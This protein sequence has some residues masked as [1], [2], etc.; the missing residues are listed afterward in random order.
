MNTFRRLKSEHSL[1]C[2][3]FSTNLLSRKRQQEEGVYSVHDWAELKHLCEREGLSK[4]AAA[5]KLGMSR[6][7][8]HRLLLLPEPPVYE[9]E[10]RSS[11]LDPYREA[12]L[13]ML[14]EDPTVRATVIRERL[15]ASGYG[16]GITIL[17][18]FVVDARPQ[19][20]AAR[21]Y[22]RTSYLPGEIG[23]VD[24][25][26]LPVRLPLRE[27]AESK[28]YALVGTLP[29]SAAHAAFFTHRKTL[30]DFLPALLDCLSR[31]GGVPSRLVLDNDTSMV[32]RVPGHRSRLHPEA[33][34]LFGALRTKPV[35]LA[36]R[37]PTS[38]GQVERTV[39]YLE[40]SFLP[41]RTFTSIEDLQAQHDT[42]T[43]EIAYRRSPRR[44]GARV[45][46]AYL[47]EKGYLSPLPDPLP[48]TDQQ[49]ETRISKDAFVRMAGADY[50]VP[51]GL[52]G[53]R[54]QIRL[55]LSSVLVYL[56][57]RE[58]ARH[59]RSYVPADVVIDPDH[60]RALLESREASK[61]LRGGDVAVEIP[62]LARYDALLGV[63]L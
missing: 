29:H 40:T 14:R 6:T 61:R 41:L 36:P 25:W 12:I 48:Q 9:R 19:F 31:L 35:I 63:T 23:Q 30:H 52:V 24:W 56:E 33:A 11:L 38:K 46:D 1:R 47:V 8:V 53:R 34:A 57:G 7:T 37:R 21:A 18:D 4:K 3:R 2:A 54:V 60:A 16:G 5:E 43:K 13:A 32:V 50:S 59:L 44:L 42:W 58:I 45:A 51:P 28:V 39:G 20:L 10:K 55:S 49:I 27:G 15:Q 26:H 22:Q 62:D 17:K